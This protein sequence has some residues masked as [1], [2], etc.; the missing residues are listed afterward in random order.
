MWKIFICMSYMLILFGNSVI[1]GSFYSIDF[2][3]KSITDDEIA[4]AIKPPRPASVSTVTNWL[5]VYIK[6]GKFGEL[7]VTKI[8]LSSNNITHKGASQLFNYISKH[9]PDLE[10]I[11]LSLNRIRDERG[12]KDCEE[13]EEALITLLEG[14]NFQTIVL[15]T[16]YLGIEWYK[17]IISKLSNDL[18]NKIIWH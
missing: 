17:Y 14:S 18:A 8:D 1:A 10:E 4:L 2:K 6:D 3:N 9:L 12:D 5:D 7:K 16:N 13:F 15:K 11:D